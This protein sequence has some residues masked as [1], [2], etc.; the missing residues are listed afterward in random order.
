MGTTVE[1]VLTTAHG[2][3]HVPA[4]LG[5]DAHDGVLEFWSRADGDDD[6]RIHYRVAESDVLMLAPVGS[7][8]TVTADRAHANDDGGVDDAAHR[9]AAVNGMM[10]SARVGIDAIASAAAAA[11][12]DGTLASGMVRRL[13]STADAIDARA[14][15]TARLIDVD[16]TSGFA[17]DGLNSLEADAARLTGII[18]STLKALE[19]LKPVDMTA[20]TGDAADIVSTAALKADRTTTPPMER[21]ANAADHEPRG[22]TTI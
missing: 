17:V 20:I 19:G 22:A 11:F 21:P 5:V 14:A 1:S 16:S 7:L 13:R 9:L 18:T 10:A 6:Y 2:S 15:A 3:W 8:L 4:G 12:P